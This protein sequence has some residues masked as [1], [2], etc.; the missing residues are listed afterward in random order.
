MIEFYEGEYMKKLSL[1]LIVLFLLTLVSCNKQEYLVT[2]DLQSDTPDNIVEISVKSGEEIDL[3]TPEKKGYTF[4]GWLDGKNMITSKKLVINHDLQLVAFYEVNKYTISF[5]KYADFSFETQVVS[6]GEPFI[7]PTP[8]IVG[9]KF[10]GWFND[11]I[12]VVDGNYSFDENITLEPVFQ[13]NSSTIFFDTGFEEKI[14]PYIVTFGSDEK[15]PEIKRTGYNFLGWYHGNRLFN[16][17]EYLCEE[18]ICLTAKWQ[19]INKITFVVNGSEVLEELY[20]CVGDIVNLPDYSLYDENFEGWYYDSNFNNLVSHFD[21]SS[22]VD[23]TLYGKVKSTEDQIIGTVNINLMN[24]QSNTYTEISIYDKNTLPSASKYWY[25]IGITKTD[26]KYY[27]TAIATSGNALADLGNYDFLILCNSKSPSYNLLVS[28]NL[29]ENMLVSFDKDL[30]NLVTGEVNMKATFIKEYTN[31]DTEF[32]KNILDEQYSSLDEVNQNINLLSYAD[33]YQLKWRSS[34][35]MTISEEGILTVP[36]TTR[37]VTLTAF[38]SDVKV[39]SFSVTVRGQNERSSALMAGYIYTNYSSITENTIK[40]LDIIYCSFANINEFGKFSNPNALSS[41]LSLID[42]YIMPYAKKY[43]TKVVISINESVKGSF[44]KIAASASLRNVFVE[45]IINLI[46]QNSFDGVDI[47][48]ECPTYDERTNFTLLMKDLYTGV[49]KQNSDLLV[50]AAIGGGKWQPRYYDLSSSAQ[51]MDY[52]NLMLYG[53]TSNNG[54]Y[55]NALYPSTQGYTLS[56]CSVDE[57]I[58]L[59]DTYNFPRNK[60]LIGLAFYGCV[61]NGSNGPGTGCTSSKSITYNLIFQ[62]YLSKNLPYIQKV[63]DEECCVPYIFDSQNKTFI[64]YENEESIKA[65]CDYINS[66]GLAGAMYWQD[67]QDHNDDLLN[68]LY[69]NIR[70]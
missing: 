42:K 39:Y 70:K 19:R 31:I 62:N 44:S 13:S 51:Y 69:D 58:A 41:L 50:T 60:I 59:Y 12:Q 56:S 33:K 26:S 43:D 1:M 54:Q 11:G 63:F 9:K 25:K 55:Q 47:D 68:A 67:G 18:D 5:Q 3:F 36:T 30:A 37:R 34:S 35:R 57:S 16:L 53:M 10:L 28:L 27:I 65:K 2:F 14:D 66:I 40:K 7:L 52:V 49:K 38:V 8:R 61:Q 46:T 6:Y 22:E 21:S 48:W 4:V 20:Y 17:N 24:K 23:I 32:I 15:L 29:Q 64:S 45:E